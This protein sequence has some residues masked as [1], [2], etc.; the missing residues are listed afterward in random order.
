MTTGYPSIQLEVNA[1]FH[2]LIAGSFEGWRLVGESVKFGRK[3]KFP[4]ENEGLLLNSWFLD[5]TPQSKLSNVI[6]RSKSEIQCP[7]W[8]NTVSTLFPCRNAL[9]ILKFHEKESLLNRFG[10][11]DQYN[12]SSCPH[13]IWVCWLQGPL[14][15]WILR[16][17]PGMPESDLTRFC[18]P[19]E[20]PSLSPPL[21]EDI[22]F[23]ES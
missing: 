21:L 7:S 9:A 2:S 4:R 16:H 5:L 14:P 22:L 17:C 23:P 19:W 12:W 15:W 13:R 3:A 6:N 10:F 11:V 20:P 1:H 8:K 18:P